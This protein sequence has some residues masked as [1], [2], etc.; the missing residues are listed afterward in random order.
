MYTQVKENSQSIDTGIYT[1]TK[2]NKLSSVMLDVSVHW[3]EL[4]EFSPPSSKYSRKPTKFCNPFIDLCKKAHLTT[5]WACRADHERA[6]STLDSP[7]TVAMDSSTQGNEESNGREKSPV[8]KGHT[9]LRLIKLD[10]T[11]TW[12]WAW[13]KKSTYLY[14]D[15][16]INCNVL[17]QFDQVWMTI[18]TKCQASITYLE[19]SRTSRPARVN[20]HTPTNRLCL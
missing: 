2:I 12:E 7:H 3:L 17:V 6:Y 5:T 18:I 4:D 10:N 11:V 8:G 9:V 1:H 13:L 16:K 14:P 20:L 15:A 19:V